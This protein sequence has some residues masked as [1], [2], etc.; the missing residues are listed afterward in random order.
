MN[1]RA[2]LTVGTLLVMSAMTMAADK[3]QLYLVTAGQGLISGTSTKKG[4]DHWIELSSC[5]MGRKGG[6]ILSSDYGVTHPNDKGLS[7]GERSIGGQPLSDRMHSDITIS[8]YSDKASALLMRAFDSDDR[9]IEVK[10]AVTGDDGKTKIG[11]LTGAAIEWIL[12][13]RAQQG[14]PKTEELS[15]TYQKITWTWKD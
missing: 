6:A 14:I 8:K 11:T 3:V 15:F 1:I 12:L 13:K 7:S 5:Q 10:I 2:T 4:Y 9:L